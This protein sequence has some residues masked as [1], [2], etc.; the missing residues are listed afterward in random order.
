M[1]GMGGALV[2]FTLCNLRLP[3]H[4]HTHTH[5]HAHKHTHTHTHTHKLIRL[6]QHGAHCCDFVEVFRVY[7]G[8]RS[9]RSYMHLTGGQDNGQITWGCKA[10]IWNSD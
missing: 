10:S 6:I 7:L 4:T 8:N 1:N 3:Q 5:T 9:V 2:G